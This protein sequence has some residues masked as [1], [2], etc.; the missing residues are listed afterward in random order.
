MTDEQKKLPPSETAAARERARERQR[1]R[2]AEQR[3]RELKANDPLFGLPPTLD[4]LPPEPPP[5]PPPAPQ[6]APSVDEFVL[7]P[8]AEL[9]A[10]P[11][12]DEPVRDKIYT[13]P[14]E[15]FPPLYVPPPRPAAPPAPKPAPRPT[16]SRV[17]NLLALLFLLATI[18]VII[19]GVIIFRDPYTPLNPLPPFTPLPIIITATFSPVTEP[20][21]PTSAP[22]ATFTPIPVEML[23]QNAPAPTATRTLQQGD[24]ALPLPDGA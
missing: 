24:P 6:A 7:P 13:P 17:Y 19:V 9:D 1:R 15:R 20:P 16:N 5:P 23:T 8:D 14:A 2:A 3:K 21:P 11:P 10:E 4:A 18:G 22:T 12:A